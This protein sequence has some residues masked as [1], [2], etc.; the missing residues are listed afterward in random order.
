MYFGIRIYSLITS[1]LRRQQ[2]KW[3]CDI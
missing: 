2:V 1:S 3:C